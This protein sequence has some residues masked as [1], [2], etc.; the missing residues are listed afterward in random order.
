[1]GYGLGV[2]VYGLAYVCMKLLSVALVSVL[3]LARIFRL[4]SRELNFFSLLLK[5][6][7]LFI[8]GLDLGFYWLKLG[9]PTFGFCDHKKFG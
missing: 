5:S 3:D 8:T 2:S 9:P 1:M 4:F 6:D 7:G